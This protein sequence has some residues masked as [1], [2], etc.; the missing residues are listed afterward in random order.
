MTVEKVDNKVELLE[1]SLFLFQSEL[2]NMQWHDVQKKVI[3]AQKLHHMCVHKAELT[4]LGK[5]IF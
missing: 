1:F 4:E 3:E 2:Q 5:Q